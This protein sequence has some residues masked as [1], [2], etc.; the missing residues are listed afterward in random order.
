MF[1]KR[2]LLA[3]RWI[4]MLIIYTGLWAYTLFQGDTAS[5]FLTYFFSFILIVLFLS[6]IYPLKAWNVNRQFAKNTY[7]DGDL[8]DMHVTFTRKS[9]YPVGY[10]LFQ[11]KLPLSFGKLNAR[12]Q[13]AYPLFKKKFTV[14]LDSFVGL[15]GIHSFPA[16]DLETSDAFGLLERSY[17]TSAEKSLTI[18]PSYFPDILEKIREATPE[19]ERNAAYWTLKKNTN[20][21]SLREFSSGDR[22]SLI[23]WKSSAKTDQLMTREF[24]NSAT[25]RLS[26]IFYGV[27][28][29]HFELSLRAAYSFIRKI[30]EENGEIRVSILGDKTTNFSP[31]AGTN[32]LQDISIAFAEL[33]PKDGVILQE[34]LDSNLHDGEKILLFTPCIDTMLMQKVSRLT[35][36]KQLQIITF[37]S[38]QAIDTKA[39]FLEPASLM[40]RWE[41]ENK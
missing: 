24:E 8:V 5:W 22:I 14:T 3:S 12:Q 10:L 29:P 11:Q 15:R 25:S 1:K 20:L 4:I 39:L 6:S 32:K 26:V 33:S 23:D 13:L 9:R 27:S 2:L 38:D 21:H 28:H 31:S 36:S 17:Q 40:S 16:I 35:D 34:S 41:R 19:N 37:E 7:H 30:S 18:Y